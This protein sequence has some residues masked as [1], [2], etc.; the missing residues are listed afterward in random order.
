MFTEILTKLIRKENLTRIETENVFSQIMS[1]ELSS[2]QIAA[3]LTALSSKG[4]SV[5]EVVGAAKI[6]RKKSNQ[7]HPNLNNF[8][9]TC[10]TGGDK[11]GTFNISTTVGFVVAAGG[12][13][14]A[15]HGNRSIT[16]KSGGADVLEALGVQIDLEPAKVEKCIEEVGIGF[17]F[18]PLFHPAMKYAMPIRQE[19]KIKTIFNLLGPLTNPANANFQL[20]GV[21][22]PELT[23][24]FA[25]VLK[26]LGIEKALVVHGDGLDE[27]TLTGETQVS[28]LYEGKIQTYK[29]KPGDFGF[30]KCNIDDLKGGDAK[31]NAQILKQ[32]LSGEMQGAKREIVLLN[33]GAAFYAGNLVESIEEGI[34]LAI[35][36]IDS[37]KAMQKLEE[38]VT[39]T[40]HV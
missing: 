30:N 32:I 29:I 26:E 33:A 22:A 14:V 4:E 28:E 10:G 31:E 11:S 36:T 6:M 34:Q 27:I 3:F 38:L 1:G 2:V 8:I 20:L 9:D 39:M 13:A 40:T 15:K 5:D 19:L 17:M 16:S 37:G 7:I 25:G 12:L 21:F 23:E 24:V 35:K 18:A